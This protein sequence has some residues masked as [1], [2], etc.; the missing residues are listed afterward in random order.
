LEQVKDALKIQTELRFYVDTE[1]LQMPTGDCA[2]LFIKRYD[3]LSGKIQLSDTCARAPM[4]GKSFFVKSQKMIDALPEMM[5]LAGLQGKV[6]VFEEVKP[7]M[8]DPVDMSKTFA[9]A[10]LGTGDILCLQNDLPADEVAQLSDPRNASVVFYYEDYRNRLTVLFKH[11]NKEKET[12]IPDL[13]LVLS[14]KNSYDQVTAK[15]GAAIHWNPANIQLWAQQGTSTKIA[16][17]R[18]PTITLYE[19]TNPGYYAPN[20]TGPTLLYFE[21]LDIAVSELDT[22]RYIKIAFVDSHQHEHDPLEILVLKTARVG[23]LVQTI[24]PQIE[25]AAGGSGR[26][27]VFETHNFRMYKT[28]REEDYVSTI[29]EYAIVYVE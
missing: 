4:A 7:S 14:K 19:M 16:V 13:E 24:A 3:P 11:K 26:L 25:L 29:T 23:D 10:E 15:L 20:V 6:K 1:D 12:L 28:Y 5:D 9:M 22:K 2:L 27:R 18:S 8:I 21:L 17:K